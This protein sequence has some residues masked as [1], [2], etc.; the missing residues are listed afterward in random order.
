MPEALIV[1]KTLRFPVLAIAEVFIQTTPPLHILVLLAF[2][3]GAF[4]LAV[5]FVI[6]APALGAGRR[7][8]RAR[9]DRPVRGDNLLDAE[10]TNT[11]RR[12]RLPLDKTCGSCASELD[13]RAS[14]R[15]P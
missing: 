13:L 4:G 5:A 7:M 10:S 3:A 11:I 12:C 15:I 8:A 9:R 6:R 2:N 1:G 14:N